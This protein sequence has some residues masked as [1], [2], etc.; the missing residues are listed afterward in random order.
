MSNE[1][2][3]WK[4][5]LPVTFSFITLMVGIA[6]DNYQKTAF[7]TDYARLIWY[8]ITYLP[9]GLPVLKEA[10][11]GFLKKSFFTEFSLMGIATIGAFAIGEYPEGVAVMVFYALGELVQNA[12][13]NNSKRNIKALL[14]VRPDTVNVFRNN[15]IESIKA[16]TVKVGEIIQLKPGEKVSL[17]GK[18][19][20][21]SASFNTAALT[22]E[23]TPDTKRKGESILAGMINLQSVVEFEVTALYENSKFSNILK[24]VFEAAG[25]KSQTQLFISKF[26]GIYTPV[27]VFLAV[28]FCVI[29]YF[30]VSD[31]VFRDWLYRSLIFLVVSCPCALVISIPLGYFGGIGAASKK[32]ILFKGAGFLDVMASVRA[33]I[34]DKTGTLTKGVF[35]VQKVVTVDI[36]EKELIQYTAALES[37]S[38]HPVST[39]IIEYAK[40]TEKFETVNDVKEIAGLGLSGNVNGKDILVGNLKLLKKFNIVYDYKA[41]KI[42]FTI[43]AVAVSNKYAGYFIIADEIKDDAKKA[44][45]NLHA[46]NVK[47]IMLSGDKQEVVDAVAKQLNIDEAYGDLLPEN[48]VYIAESIKKEHTVVA[49]VGDG[50]NDA[51]VIALAD[52]GIAMGGLGS[53]VAIETADIVIQ[54]DQPTKISTA[55]SIGKATKRIVWQNVGFAFIV[56]LVIL[57]LGAGGLATMWEAVFADVGVALLA[58]LNATR[59]RNMK[60]I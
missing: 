7:F 21:E 42:P 4:I 6:L 15:V 54:N 12:A 23:S 53:D 59:I 25:R 9:V 18:L 45:E 43:V 46:A 2:F 31:Y 52:A 24:M 22:G 40:E 17:D 51:P 37:K 28:S 35:S 55:I 13:V 47:T 58:I 34:L 41:D 26:A 5:Y 38:T 30:F 32:G 11:N 3:E 56:K 49:F 27:V 1:P 14:D 20:T 19:I 29:P 50:V 44:I 33:V 48:K 60:F 16:E 8:I 57:F 10:W 36:S 39:A